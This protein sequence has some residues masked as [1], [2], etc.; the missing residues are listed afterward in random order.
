[1]NLKNGEIFDIHGDL[2]EW[3]RFHLDLIIG[4]FV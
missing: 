2:E 4:T 1:V 3:D